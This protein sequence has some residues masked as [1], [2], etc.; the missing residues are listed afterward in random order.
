VIR[1]HLSD[2]KPTNVGFFYWNAERVC[3]KTLGFLNKARSTA[4]Q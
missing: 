2:Q 1:V 3:V 4:A